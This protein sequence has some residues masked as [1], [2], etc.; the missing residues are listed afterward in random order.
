MHTRIYTHVL[1][2]T[3]TRISTCMSIS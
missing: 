2:H 1:I 3:H